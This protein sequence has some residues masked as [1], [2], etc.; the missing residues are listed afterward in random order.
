M[1]YT[2]FES[3]LEGE[4]SNRIVYHNHIIIIDTCTYVCVCM[5]FAVR[6]CIKV[7]MWSDGRAYS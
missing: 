7:C 1:V 2:R 4:G 3:Y 5:Y 6:I